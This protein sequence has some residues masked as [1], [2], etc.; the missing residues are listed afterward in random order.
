MSIN[1][2]FKNSKKTIFLTIFIFLI[3]VSC[4]VFFL[5]LPN[6]KSIKE[7]GIEIKKQR[8][9]LEET[10]NKVSNSGN[11]SDNVS[12]LNEKI[13][14]IQS[15]FMK[16]GNELDFIKILETTATKNNIF[17]KISP[18]LSKDNKDDSFSVMNLKL[19]LTGSFSNV[20]NYIN[21]IESLESYINITS[22][23]ISKSKESIRVDNSDAKDMSEISCIIS[24]ETY[25]K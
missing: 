15:I 7:R 5:I 16:K 25:W 13:S 9:E 6:I 12:D 18:E 2:N 1:L 10:I 22:V 8:L 23:N 14:S 3:S 17:Q 20:L 11:L 21:D 24:A 4:L 19:N